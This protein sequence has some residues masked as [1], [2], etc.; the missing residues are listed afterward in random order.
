MKPMCDLH[1]QTISFMGRP[2]LILFGWNR[3]LRFI[4]LHL[5]LAH[6]ALTWTIVDAGLTRTRMFSLASCQVRDEMA[7]EGVPPM[8]DWIPVEDLPEDA[9]CRT[10]D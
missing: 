1:K 4:F 6:S 9:E 8:Y 5:T 7:T 2:N 3:N 10:L